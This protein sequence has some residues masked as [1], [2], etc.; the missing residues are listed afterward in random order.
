MNTPF[1]NQ[2]VNVFSTSQL[3]I[4]NQL[5]HQS[6]HFFDHQI[7]SFKL[8]SQLVGTEFKGKI[9]GEC[10]YGLSVMINLKGKPLRGF[11][12]T[13]ENR[14][15]L[16]QLELDKSLTMNENTSI[17]SPLFVGEQSE[18]TTSQRKKRKYVKSGLYRKN[19]NG[20][21]LYSYSERNYLKNA[22]HIESLEKPSFVKER[23]QVKK[24]MNAFNF[25]VEEKLK[26]SNNQN[27]SNFGE[28]W[29]ALPEHERAKYHAQAL[30]AKEEFL[31]KYPQFKVQ[32]PDGKTHVST[33]KYEF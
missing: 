5:E 32:Q 21:F 3:Y 11:L 19:K 7:C 6:N 8:D 23:L 9:E 30:K 16:F 33:K 27:R 1:L 31:K 26:S 28:L 29:N 18:S 25:F 13:D 12:F 22:K 10:E 24:P 20:T 17:P 14:E 2:N 15:Y 4:N